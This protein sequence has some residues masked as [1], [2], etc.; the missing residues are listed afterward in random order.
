M[1]NADVSLHDCR[2]NHIQYEEQFIKFFIPDGFYLIHG[3]DSSE[4]TESYNAEV[5][6]RFMDRYEERFRVTVYRK[7]IFGQTVREDRTD[8]F[9]SAVNAGKVEFEFVYTYRSYHGVLFKGYLWRKK[10]PWWRECEIELMTD[11]ITYS[12]EERAAERIVTVK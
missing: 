12:W 1:E 8:R 6:C 4:P 2:T 11:E 7:N 5:T 3:A 9:V 10:K